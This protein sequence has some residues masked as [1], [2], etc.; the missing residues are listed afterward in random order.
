VILV[1]GDAMVDRYW[2]GTVTRISPEAPVPVLYYERVEER[3][4][5]AAN[6]ARNAQAMGAEV[7]T[8]FSCDYQK[9]PVVKLRLVAR[10]QQIARVDFDVAQTPVDINEV[11]DKASGCAVAVLSDYAKG[12]L[13]D[14]R[15][16]IVACRE[17]GAMVL[18]D[19]KGS[20]AGRYAEADVIKPNHYEM[21]ALVGPWRDEADLEARAHALCR[22]HAIGAVLM[23]RGERGMSLFRD[24]SVQ[25]LSG[26]RLELY[27]VSGA[28]DTVIA[29]LAASLDRG[30]QLDQAAIY[31]NKA[32]GIAVTR[33]GTSVVQKSEVFA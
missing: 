22:Q 32:A 13:P 16:V 33:F 15:A 30:D 5:G 26:R 6:V 25:H 23:T 12:A 9:H 18:V 2:F 24:G 14:P 8:V 17:A 4:G 7:R 29:A 1:T 11:R 3:E 21:Q 10:T 20:D 19:P 27:D 28:G 31:A